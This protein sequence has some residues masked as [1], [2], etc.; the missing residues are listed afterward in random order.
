MGA[1]VSFQSGLPFMFVN[2]LKPLLLALK[3][4]LPTVPPTLVLDLDG[5]GTITEED[6]PEARPI[7]ND[8]IPFQSRTKDTALKEVPSL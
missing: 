1:R 5:K 7:D 4:K 6:T 3:V 2:L 8:G